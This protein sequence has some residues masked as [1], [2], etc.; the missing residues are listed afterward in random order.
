MRGEI[1]AEGYRSNGVYNLFYTRYQNTGNVAISCQSY[2]VYQYTRGVDLKTES[3]TETTLKINP[4]GV[5]ETTITDGYSN[6]SVIDRSAKCTKWPF[7]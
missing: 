6:I 4:G 2:Y 3:R 1:I 7:D 5:A